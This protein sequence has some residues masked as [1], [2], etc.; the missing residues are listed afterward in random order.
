MGWTPPSDTGITGAS[1]E[2]R[3]RLARRALPEK[4]ELRMDYLISR[5]AAN[6]GKLFMPMFDEVQPLGQAADGG[7][8]VTSVRAVLQKHNKVLLAIFT[9]SSQNALGKIMMSDG[10]AN[11][12]FAQLQTF[13][14][15][16]RYPSFFTI[17][18]AIS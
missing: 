8:A 17:D 5:L 1:I 12:Q 7:A 18:S 11:Y 16:K 10:G 4:P 14:S 3:E 13:P 9:G 2:I 6:A 15:H